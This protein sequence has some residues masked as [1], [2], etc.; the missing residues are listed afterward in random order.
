MEF[1]NQRIRNRKENPKDDYPFHCDICNKG[2]MAY[3]S[4]KS[5]CNSKNHWGK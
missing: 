5:H 4:L 3:E 1:E 2:F